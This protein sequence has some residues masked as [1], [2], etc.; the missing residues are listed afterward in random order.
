MQSPAYRRSRTRAV[1]RLRSSTWH[2]GFTLALA[3]ALW[4]IRFEVQNGLE[5]L[6]LAVLAEG[7]SERADVGTTWYT[8]PT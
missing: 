5:V 4:L 7:I 2:C 3:I 1:P 8:C 6:V